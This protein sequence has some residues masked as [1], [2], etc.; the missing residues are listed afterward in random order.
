[1]GIKGE[2]KKRGEKCEQVESWEA[3]KEDR[4][5]EGTDTGSKTI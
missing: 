2:G 3:R 1:M 5:L 4:E